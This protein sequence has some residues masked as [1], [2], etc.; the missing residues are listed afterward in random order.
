[1]PFYTKDER[2]HNTTKTIIDKAM[3]LHIEKVKEMIK[4]S[5]YFIENPQEYY[6]DISKIN[7]CEINII[8]CFFTIDIDKIV[9][10]VEYY[11]NMCLITTSVDR[12]KLEEYKAKKREEFLSRLLTYPLGLGYMLYY[13]YD[14][15][16]LT[17]KYNW[18][19]DL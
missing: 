4:L 6:E 2:R 1:M 16:I 3:G 15:N 13:L 10:R 11:T 9:I 5:P 8:G 19:T 17:Y 12:K 7:P 14:N 18:E